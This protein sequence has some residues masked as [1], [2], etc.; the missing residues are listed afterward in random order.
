MSWCSILLIHKCSRS[1]QPWMSSFNFRF[2]LAH[3][4]N[5]LVRIQLPIITNKPN[6]FTFTVDRHPDHYLNIQIPKWIKISLS[7]TKVDQNISFKH[8]NGSK[9]MDHTEFGGQIN[10]ILWL[11]FANQDDMEPFWHHFTYFF[12]IL[13]NRNIPFS[14]MFACTRVLSAFGGS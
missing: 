5:V 2:E 8:L 3:Q 12:G 11:F 4:A 9:V 7:N 14:T 6:R 10:P 13:G 1:D